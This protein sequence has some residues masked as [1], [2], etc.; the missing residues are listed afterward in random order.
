MHKIIMEKFIKDLVKGSGRI[1]KKQF[2][3]AGTQGKSKND[4]LD[5]VTL[6]DLSSEKFIISQI[7]NRFPKHQILSEESGDNELQSDYL[8]VIDPLD[9]TLNFARGIPV[10]VSQVA[11]IEKGEIMLTAVF[12][13]INDNLFFAKKGKGAFCNG[14]KISCSKNSDIDASLLSM[15]AYADKSVTAFLDK[16]SDF[17]GDSKLRVRNIGSI[18]MGSCDVACGKVDYL[19]N[20]SG[21]PWDYA[22]VYLLLK[23]AGCEVK[24]IFGKDWQLSDKTMI[25]GNKKLVQKVLKILN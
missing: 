18:G 2:N 23:E 13:P 20:N 24:N 22:P 17:R 21:M 9:G 6:A 7:K 19:I 14:R 5:M 1:L 16:I 10:F 11:F 3:I 8:W 4:V 15:N 25:A 12:D